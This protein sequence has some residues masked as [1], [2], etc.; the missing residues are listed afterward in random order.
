MLDIQRQR[1]APNAGNIQFTRR[2]LWMQIALLMLVSGLLTFHGLFPH[3][4]I[5]LLALMLAALLI[6]DM[7]GACDWC[8]LVLALLSLMAGIACMLLARFPPE[9]APGDG[10]SVTVKL[11][12]IW[13]GLAG[14]AFPSLSACLLFSSEVRYTSK[15][16]FTLW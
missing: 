5:C 7:Q 4:L 6:V 15:R 13:A 1:H 12:P 14:L 3:A 9:A 11:I 2:I 8:R 16:L 10:G